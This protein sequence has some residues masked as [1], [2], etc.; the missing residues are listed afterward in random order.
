MSLCVVGLKAILILIAVLCLLV[1][2][3]FFYLGDPPLRPTL[4]FYRSS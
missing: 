4:P 2:Y 3:G 1:S